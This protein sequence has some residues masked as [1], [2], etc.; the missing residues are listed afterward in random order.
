MTAY[1]IL[2]WLYAGCWIFIVSFVF[3][4]IFLVEWKRWK[5]L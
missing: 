1:R 3:G 2:S 5:G 4:L